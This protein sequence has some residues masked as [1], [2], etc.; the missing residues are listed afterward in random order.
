M[1]TLRRSV[2]GIRK[3]DAIDLEPL[4]VGSGNDRQMVILYGALNHLIGTDVVVNLMESSP[5]SHRPVESNG[6]V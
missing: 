5:K 6:P 2:I 4:Y 3:A 1:K